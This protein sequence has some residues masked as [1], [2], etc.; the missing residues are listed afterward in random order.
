MK[1]DLPALLDV[2]MPDEF[3]IWIVVMLLTQALAFF[4]WVRR[5]MNKCNSPVER[6]VRDRYFGGV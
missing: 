2:P 4:L 6:L 5:D 1:I 3:Q